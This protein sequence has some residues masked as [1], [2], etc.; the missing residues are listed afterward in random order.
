[1]LRGEARPQ[2]AVERVTV[3]HAIYQWKQDPEHRSKA[4][5]VQSNNRA[6][7]ESAFSRG[8]AVVGYERDGEGNGSFLLVPWNDAKEQTRSYNAKR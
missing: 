8:L 5:Q 1:M 2:E 6:A 3:P 7:L 4:Q